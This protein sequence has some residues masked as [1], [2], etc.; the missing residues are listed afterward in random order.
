M[1]A[2]GRLDLVWFNAPY[3]H[4]KVI[5][6][7]HSPRAGQ[8]QILRLRPATH[9]PQAEPLRPEHSEPDRREARIRL[10]PA[11]EEIDERTDKARERRARRGAPQLKNH[12]PE[13]FRAARDL[14]ELREAYRMLHR[15]E[16]MEEA[17][18]TVRRLAYDELL[19]LQVS[20]ALKRAE[21]RRHAPACHR[22][23]LDRKT[24]CAASALASP[25]SSPT[26]RTT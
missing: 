1:D 15:P 11:S 12:L 19:M 16:S 25:S 26:R 9:Q 24:R 7:M 5:P 6:G 23:P 2:T 8:S 13:S 22:P 10:Y 18:R 20:I 21:L 17:A 4:N 3:M 14:P